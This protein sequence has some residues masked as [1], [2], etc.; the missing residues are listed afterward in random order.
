MKLAYDMVDEDKLKE[1]ARKFIASSPFLII[2][3]RRSSESCVDIPCAGKQVY[4][5]PEVSMNYH[6][7]SL[8]CQ[9]DDLPSGEASSGGRG[10]DSPEKTMN[11]RG[12]TATRPLCHSRKYVSEHFAHSQKCRTACEFLDVQIMATR[13]ASQGLSEQC[14]R[15][16]VRC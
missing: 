9:P 10:A 6:P 8:C 4:S 2:S 16:V 7:G 11:R 15:Q 5:K 13:C 3:E 14:V 1:R 12:T